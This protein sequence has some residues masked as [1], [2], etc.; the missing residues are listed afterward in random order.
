MGCPGGEGVTSRLG[1]PFLRRG[2]RPGG[3]CVI[4]SAGQWTAYLGLYLTPVT[5]PRSP[6]P[7]PPLRRAS[8]GLVMPEAAPSSQRRGHCA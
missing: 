6:L 4:S 1:A 2:R 5:P 7:A 8:G 3:G